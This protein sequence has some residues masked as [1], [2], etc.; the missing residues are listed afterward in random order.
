VKE[1]EV[2]P[3]STEELI[4]IMEQNGTEI[5]E[6]LTTLRNYKIVIFRCYSLINDFSI[7]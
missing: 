7:L 6:S 5:Q 4:D 1:K 3:R 2:G